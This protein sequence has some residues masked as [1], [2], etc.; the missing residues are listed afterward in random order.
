MIRNYGLVFLMALLSHSII[1]T[2]QLF[3][4]DVLQG[5]WHKVVASRK[6]NSNVL[7]DENRLKLDAQTNLRKSMGIMNMIRSC[8]YADLFDGSWDKGFAISKFIHV[9]PEFWSISNFLKLRL[10]PIE[11]IPCSCVFLE[12]GRPSEKYKVLVHY[13]NGMVRLCAN[14][15]T[16]F[17]MIKS[18][19]GFLKSTGYPGLI[20]IAIGGKENCCK[21]S[22]DTL[23][24]LLQED[25]FE[26]FSEP[27]I[28]GVIAHE[29]GHGYYDDGASHMYHQSMKLMGGMALLD[30]SARFFTSK[31]VVHGAC[32]NLLGIAVLCTLYYGMLS[33]VAEKRADIFAAEMGMSDGL[34]TLLKKYKA[35]Q[36][37]L[38]N[39]SFQLLW[40]IWSHPVDD[41]RIDYLEAWKKTKDLQ[42]RS[43]GS[44][45]VLEL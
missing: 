27:E 29:L 5:N 18:F 2:S 15:A 12:D 16:R 41:V 9:S 22:G 3:Y 34:I 38:V 11:L 7:S 30:V 21:K 26:R 33:R 28:L 4:T 1:H 36:G 42:K 10:S 17:Q 37:F 6:V 23:L 25:I 45:S 20:A 43:K 13:E 44:G 35:E 40:W 39:W 32:R 19:G 31:P 14:E 8:S 24:I